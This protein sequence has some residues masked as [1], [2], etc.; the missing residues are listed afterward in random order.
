MNIIRGGEEIY[1]WFEK[2]STADPLILTVIHATY[3][4]YA[5]EEDRREDL[6]HMA[7][8]KR[9]EKPKGLKRAG[10]AA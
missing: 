3:L 8:L 10:G 1:F 6:L 4:Y 9:L 7:E 5:V 2:L